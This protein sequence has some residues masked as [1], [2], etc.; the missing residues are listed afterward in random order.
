L[1]SKIHNDWRLHDARRWRKARPRR[2]TNWTALRE[3]IE[4][5]MESGLDGPSLSLPREDLGPAQLS[6]TNSRK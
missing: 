3:E 1:I 2:S 6:A 4:R 5:L